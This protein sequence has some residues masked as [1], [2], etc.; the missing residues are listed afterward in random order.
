MSH[1]RRRTRSR[2]DQEEEEE[3][4]QEEEDE[5]DQSDEGGDGG[6]EE[7]CWLVEITG[8]SACRQVE[9]RSTKAE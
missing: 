8:I 2:E 3:G 5:E 6:N 4:E 9:V 1:G 7:M